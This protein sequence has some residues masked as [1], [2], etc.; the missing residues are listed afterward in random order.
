MYFLKNDYS[1]GAHPRVMEA[2]S[3]TNLEQTVGYGLDPYCAAAAERLRTRFAC[4]NADI[5]FLPGGTQTNLTVIAAFLRPWEAVVAAST[6]HI[7]VHETGAIEAAGHRVCLIPSADGKITAGELRALLAEYEVDN[8]EHMVL[9]RMV[10]LSQP[11]EF[12]TIYSRAEL[13]AISALC[14]ERGLWLYVDGARLAVSLTCGPNDL[15]PEDFAQL[16]DA[17]YLGGTKN[18]LLFGEALFIVNDALKP[19]FRNC[20]KQRGGLLAKGRLLGV[21]FGAILEDDLWLT[22]AAHANR[23]AD[24]LREGIRAAGFSL[25]VNSPTNQIFPIVPD[26][27]AEALKREFVFEDWCPAGDGLRAIRLVT[28]WA[29]KEETVQA[30]LRA[31]KG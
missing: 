26:R 17:F 25:F 8:A 15:R 2:L 22:V 16:C 7:A 10:Y 24:A 6:A 13:S 3:R 21:Q 14:R 12:G 23:M 20:I 19:F 29:T 11:T 31:V 1:E 4:P 30:L 5:H 28:S 27:F 18:A 9:P